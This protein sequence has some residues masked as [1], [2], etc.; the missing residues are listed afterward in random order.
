MSFFGIFSKVFLYNL[1]MFDLNIIRIVIILTIANVTV[2]S[3]YLLN[4]II[5][6]ILKDIYNT[7]GLKKKI[8]LD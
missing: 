5:I 4:E 8:I 7:N 3:S 1:Q 2:L 6:N